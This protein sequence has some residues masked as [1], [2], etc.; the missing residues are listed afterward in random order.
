VIILGY[1]NDN[2]NQPDA[3]GPQ[4]KINPQSPNF[5]ANQG[6]PSSPPSGG[7]SVP[8][9]PPPTTPT[10]PP[11]PPPA[12]N[13][14]PSASQGGVVP[15]PP[16]RQVDIRTMN[17]DQES[18]KASGGLGTQPKTVST[19]APV[20]A[21]GKGKKLDSA[22]PR[23]SDKKKALFIGLGIIVFL[24]AAA[25]VANYL[26]L[27]MFLEDVEVS[28]LPE[29]TEA[30]PA[31]DQVVTPTVNTFVHQSYFEESTD[32]SGE[33]N[34][35]SLTLPN[36]DASLTSFANLEASNVA[37]SMSEFNVTEGLVATPVSADETLDVLLPDVNLAT[38]LEEDFT[39]FLYFDGTTYYPGYI[40]ALDGDVTD[41][42]VM[43]GIF[44]TDFESSNSLES[45]FLDDPGAPD[46]SGFQDGMAVD[47]STS[48]WMAFSNEG[49]SLNYA[50]KGDFLV[51]STSFDGFK[52]AIAKLG[53]AT[54]PA[55]QVVEQEEP[56]DETEGGAPVEGETA[57]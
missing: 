38:P 31:E 1:M 41:D 12:P 14:Q 39:G 3:G 28:D 19:G 50:W 34:L 36:L 49:V 10:P 20:P 29:I 15:P 5:M 11:P 32:V 17:S 45:F 51:I 47:G 55:P 30:P 25:A 4:D 33:I 27:P 7:S 37:G 23:G 57:E 56:A 48:R 43:K 8:P 53:D 35:N 52:E 22:A 46:A 42:E 18:L 24:A 54:A 9:P 13:A 16:P 21:P 2:T 40:F 44:R 6:T 26:I